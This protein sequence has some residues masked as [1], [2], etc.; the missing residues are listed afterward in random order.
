[1]EALLGAEYKGNFTYTGQSTLNK[2]LA[3]QLF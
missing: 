3:N 2:M 1:M